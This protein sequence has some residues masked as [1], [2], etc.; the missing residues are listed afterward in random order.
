MCADGREGALARAK[1]RL[2]FH[3]SRDQHGLVVPGSE[4]P[5][6]LLAGPREIGI[7]SLGLGVF[8][9]ALWVML[10]AM[11]LL[12]SISLYPLIANKNATGFTANYTLAFTNA[13]RPGIRS[14]RPP[15]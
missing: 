2:L 14:P 13:V 7:E 5:F 9:T 10:F 1:A 4:E 11:L 3:W 6:G 15:S 12:A 8:F